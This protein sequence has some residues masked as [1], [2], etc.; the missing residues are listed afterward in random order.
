[1]KR[2]ALFSMHFWVNILETFALASN[3]QT[4][5]TETFESNSKTEARAIF[6]EFFPVF[7]GE[8][9]ISM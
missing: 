6:T 7:G 5:R 8:Y 9:P 3:A 2:D 1:V 4:K